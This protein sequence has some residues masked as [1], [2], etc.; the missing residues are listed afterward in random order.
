METT[1]PFNVHKLVDG[2]DVRG[3]LS[4][5]AVEGRDYQRARVDD[6]LIDP[7]LDLSLFDVISQIDVLVQDDAQ[8][9]IAHFTTVSSALDKV[10]TFTRVFMLEVE[11]Y[12]V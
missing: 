4:R 10:I 12:I 9:I 3:L 6:L 5:E 11:D 8:I 2:L 1:N 7:N